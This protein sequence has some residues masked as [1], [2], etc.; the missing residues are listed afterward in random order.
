[1]SDK[2][3]EYPV[4][5]AVF[6]IAAGYFLARAVYVRAKYARRRRISGFWSAI[7]EGKSPPKGSGVAVFWALVLFGAFI[8]LGPFLAFEADMWGT[9]AKGQTTA[10]RGLLL[11]GIL[12]AP[13]LLSMTVPPVLLNSYFLRSGFEQQSPGPG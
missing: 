5:G 13:L 10:S 6:G 9:V 11:Q 8:G 2:L 3:W 1:M 4:F 12:A 7:F